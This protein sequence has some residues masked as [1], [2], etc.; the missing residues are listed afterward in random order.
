MYSHQLLVL[1]AKYS[2]VKI[3]MS[4]RAAFFETCKRKLAFVCSSFPENKWNIGQ[5]DV[6][7]D[8]DGEPSS[9]GHRFYMPY[10]LR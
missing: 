6:P 7:R 1:K 5:F 2:C 9:V 3:S 8:L 4:S 10:V